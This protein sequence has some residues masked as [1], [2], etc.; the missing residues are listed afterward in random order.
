MLANVLPKPIFIPK[1]RPTRGS[2]KSK[3]QCYTWWHIFMYVVAGQAAILPAQVDTA[4][5]SYAA[6]PRYAALSG[7][8]SSSS[9]SYFWWQMQI[10]QKDLILYKKF[11]YIFGYIWNIFSHRYQIMVMFLWQN[12]SNTPN[13]E[14]ILLLVANLKCWKFHYYTNA[15]Q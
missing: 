4:R 12:L 14:F 7:F 10:W 11:P 6:Q 13:F 2:P 15:H 1:C 9:S 8:F 5:L 3:P